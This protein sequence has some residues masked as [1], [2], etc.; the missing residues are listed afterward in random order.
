M[1][2]FSLSRIIYESKASAEDGR[3]H[4]GLPIFPEIK[5]LWEAMQ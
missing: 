4:L 1:S 2:E 5:P 3:F